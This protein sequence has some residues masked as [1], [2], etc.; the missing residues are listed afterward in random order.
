ML[1]VKWENW[2]VAELY[3][4]FKLLDFS[5]SFNFYDEYSRSL[6]LSNY[7]IEEVNKIL[8]DTKEGWAFDSV[9]VAKNEELSAKFNKHN[10]TTNSIFQPLQLSKIVSLGM[11][12]VLLSS[13]GSNAWVVS[14]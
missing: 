10:Y 11:P 5:T 9:T 1:G 2:T 7:S 13:E 6:L 3:L 8:P 4:N 14:G 12:E